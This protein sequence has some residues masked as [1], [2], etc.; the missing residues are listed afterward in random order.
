[1]SDLPLKIEG[2]RPKK[3]PLLNENNLKIREEFV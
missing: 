3:V 2:E 1:M